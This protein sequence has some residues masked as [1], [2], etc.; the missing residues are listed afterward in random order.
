V[1]NALGNAVAGIVIARWQGETTAA[2]M[3]AIMSGQRAGVVGDPAG[4]RPEPAAV[5]A[6]S[7]S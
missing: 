1:V 6:G 3:S 5:P 7:G 2:Q 4:D